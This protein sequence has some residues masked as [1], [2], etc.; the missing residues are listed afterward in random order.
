MHMNDPRAQRFNAFPGLYGLIFLNLEPL[1]TLIPAIATVFVPGGAAWFY[2]EQV[3]G[4]VI[5]S[6][7]GPHTRM[8][9]GQLV[10]AYAVIGM[11]SAF[12]FR[13]VR[14]AIPNNPAAQEQIIGASLAVLAIADISHIVAT[15]VA[16]PWEVISNPLV[17]NGTT[18]GN[19]GGSA[20]F[21]L[22]RTAWF[23]GIGRQT[24]NRSQKDK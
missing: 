18:W 23:A 10:N 17:W 21:L 11:S 1:S 2:N 15:M 14:K 13:A 4:G 19:I 7:D 9:L 24:A 12:G 20:F 8:V 22:L 16:L 3:P 5:Q 6:V